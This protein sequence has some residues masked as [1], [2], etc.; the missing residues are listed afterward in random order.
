[1][2]KSQKIKPILLIAGEGGHLEQVRRFHAQ[3]HVHCNNPFIV[4]TDDQ[5]KNVEFGCE[6]IRMKN[7]SEY[8]KQRTF[9]NQILFVLLLLLELIKVF[10][11]VFKLKP[12]G[13]IMFGPLFCLPFAICSKVLGVKTVFIETWSKFFEPTKTAKFC[14]NIVNRIYFQNKTLKKKLPTGIYGGKL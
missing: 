5:A 11:L 1:M 10:I 2:S 12:Q 4:I 9:I 8:S 14:K 7:L 13:T 6:V 3:N